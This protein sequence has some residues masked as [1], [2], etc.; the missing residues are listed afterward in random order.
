MFRVPFSEHA[1]LDSFFA[2]L[3][4][5]YF[6]FLITLYLLFDSLLHCL[7]IQPQVLSTNQQKSLNPLLFSPHLCWFGIFKCVERPVL[8]AS[9]YPMKTVFASQFKSN[10]TWMIVFVGKKQ[11]NMNVEWK[12]QINKQGQCSKVLTCSQSKCC[13][14]TF[15]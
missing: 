12:K 10:L 15:Q 6:S 1:L 11:P 9:Q 8:F 3:S 2:T 14:W 13:F 5:C 7:Q 4:H